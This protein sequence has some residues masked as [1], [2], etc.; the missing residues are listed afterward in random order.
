MSFFG[1]LRLRERPTKKNTIEMQLMLTLHLAVL[2]ISLQHDVS[3]T[4]TDFVG[5]HM[6]PLRLKLRKRKNCEQGPKVLKLL[7]Q[8]LPQPFLFSISVAQITSWWWAGNKADFQQKVLWWHFLVYKEYHRCFWLVI[9]LFMTYT[10]A[11]ANS[12]HWIYRLKVRLNFLYYTLFRK[13]A[14][15][16]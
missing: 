11:R 10:H 5:Q 2:R 14:E 9:L 16:I 6:V 4:L 15:L 1:K 3:A 12:F 8:Q 13:K 7:A